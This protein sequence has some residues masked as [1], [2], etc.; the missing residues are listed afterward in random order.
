MEIL[1][2][3]IE[4]PTP[5]ETF[6]IEAGEGLR[7]SAG[8]TL[9]LQAGGGA[10]PILSD[11]HQVFTMDRNELM[12]GAGLDKAKTVGWRYLGGPQGP[13]GGGAPSPSVV[14]EVAVKNG[15]PSFTHRQEG[16]LAKRTRETMDIASK[17]PE[18][19]SGS[20]ELRMLR[21]PSVHNTDAIWLKN[22]GSGGDLVIPIASKSPEL[23]SGRKYSADDFLKVTR[24]LAKGASFDNS[25][26]SK[27]TSGA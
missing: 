17:L 19:S 7:R 9:G 14:A 25:P 24:E 6:R 18:V 27:L 2:M 10:Q 22:K 3:A 1:N 13:L 20:Y 15:V 12:A 8:Q 11:P 26:R 5:P 23:V 16:W 21:L 4:R